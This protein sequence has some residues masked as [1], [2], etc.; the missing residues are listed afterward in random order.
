MYLSIYQRVLAQEWLSTM[1]GSRMRKR[2]DN[3]MLLSIYLSIYLIYLSI[4]PFFSGTGIGK[5]SNKNNLNKGKKKS[6]IL[7]SVNSVDDDAG[8]SGMYSDNS[9]ESEGDTMEDDNDQ[10]KDDEYGS[11]GIEKPTGLSI[12]LSI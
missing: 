12:F 2:I 10:Y 9:E 5:K 8:D 11:D 6:Q 3:S 1:E 4:T 7:S